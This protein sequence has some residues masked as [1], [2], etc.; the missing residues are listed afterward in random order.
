MNGHGAS[1]VS[2]VLYIV[3][4]SHRVGDDPHTT[5]ESDEGG[6][7]KGHVRTRLLENGRRRPRPY[8]GRWRR[9][10][11]APLRI[12]DSQVGR[13]RQTSSEPAEG[14]RGGRQAQAAHKGAQ[15]ARWALLVRGCILRLAHAHLASF[16]GAVQ[17]LQS[18]GVRR[19]LR[20]HRHERP[21]QEQLPAD[22][23]RLPAS[24]L[25]HIVGESRPGAPNGAAG[26]GTDFAAPATDLHYG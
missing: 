8:A 6:G 9:C 16:D 19:Q 22:R 14:E 7:R 3:K 15:P 11:F 24:G 26:L 1:R 10:P 21:E 2:G 4:G 18:D 25:S 12:T 23:G 13:G 20:R 17:L 5:G